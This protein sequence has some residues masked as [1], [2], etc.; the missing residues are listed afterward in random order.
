MQS[1]QDIPKLEHTVRLTQNRLTAGTAFLAPVKIKG[2]PTYLT[3]L[4]LEA[5]PVKV[6]GNVPLINPVKGHQYL[7][8]I[9]KLP[10][11]ESQNFKPK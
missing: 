8:N 10:E 2:D 7:F 6:S 9:G 4:C 3:Q 11:K 5:G 1:T